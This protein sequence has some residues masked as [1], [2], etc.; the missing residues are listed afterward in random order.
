LAA[1]L[2]TSSSN[3]PPPA[4][5]LSLGVPLMIDTRAYQTRAWPIN[6]LDAFAMDAL[7]PDEVLLPRPEWNDW[8]KIRN[9][10]LDRGGR[11]T[12]F[13]EA[14]SSFDDA[15]LSLPDWTYFDGNFQSARYF[16][17]QEE[18]IRRDFAFAAPTN[19]ANRRP[20]DEI[21]GT[22][23]V[24]LHV[25]RDDYVTD[26]RANRVHGTLDLDFYRGAT[27]LIAERCG[28]AP[29]FFAFSE[30]PGWVAANLKL[31][32]PLRLVTHNDPCHPD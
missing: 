3:M 28:A 31:D 11:F 24:S 16:A 5:A 30:D 4:G 12:V 1:A 9:R 22:M 18:H 17:G 14:G 10:L 2:A 26:P 29:T 25:R 20:A 21:T 32:F 27:Q 7:P 6:V 13:K 8:H 15:V 19:E 23:A